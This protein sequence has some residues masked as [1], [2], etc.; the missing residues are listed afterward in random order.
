MDSPSAKP[1]FA[2]ANFRAYIAGRFL[3]AVAGHIQTVAVGLYV[4]ALTRDPL[5]LG[6]AGLFT[7]LP[8]L[9]LVAVAGHV[10]DSYD[11]RLVSALSYAVACLSSILL[12]SLVL[13]QV[14]W[15]GWFYLAIALVG[16]S[17]VFGMPANQAMVAN[18]VAPF[19]RPKAVAWSASA[20]QSATILGPAAGGFLYLL[21]PEVTFLAA[22]IGH[23]L[24]SLCMMAISRQVP[25]E[26]REPFSLD[27]FRKGAAFIVG[28][29]VLL[30][31]LSL[32]LVGVLF[33]GT[34]ALLPIFATDILD[35]GPQ[36]LGWLRTSQAAGALGM[37]LFLARFPIRSHAGIWLFSAAAMFGLAIISFGLSRLLWL[38]ML[39]MVVEGAADMVSV[40]IRST[41]IQNETPDALRGRV[42]SVNSLFIGASNSLGEFESGLAARLFGVVPATVGG[43]VI[44]VLTTLVWAR[45]FPMLRTRNTL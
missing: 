36:G 31:A 40:V 45:L 24:A 22:A 1:V 10:A 8:Q 7:F 41:L 15:V 26:R 12:I 30:G 17:R 16:V 28:N 34:V 35:S 27:A 23:G 9:L 33:A 20:I 21:G 42:S 14:S 25:T 44:S 29:K 3:T 11:R 43:G 32:D 39:C 6:L 37:A 2:L 5:A 19:Q 13:F 18:L 38:S 4:Y